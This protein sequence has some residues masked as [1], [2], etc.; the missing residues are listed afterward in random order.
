MCGVSVVQDGQASCLN[1]ASCLFR[2]YFLFSRLSALWLVYVRVRASSSPAMLI[3][4]LGPWHAA[5]QSVAV[6]P[7]RTQSE[8]KK[9]MCKH[10]VLR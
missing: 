7:V 5:V 6:R 1:R 3:D 2:H 10:P 9:Q 4:V 8:G